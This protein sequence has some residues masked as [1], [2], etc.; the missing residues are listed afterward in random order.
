MLEWLDD[1]GEGEGSRLSPPS[2][3]EVVLRA[4][5]LIAISMR[6]SFENLER[7]S[8]SL[9]NWTPEQLEEL[10][11]CP[12]A[13]AAWMAKEGLAPSLSSSERRLMEAPLGE[14]TDQELLDADWRQESLGVLLWALSIIPALPPYDSQFDLSQ[15][16]LIRG[17]SRDELAESA[18]KRD[19]EEISRARGVAEL[20]HWRSRTTRLQRDGHAPPPGFPRQLDTFGKIIRVTADH[21]FANS[22]IPRPVRHDFPAFGKPYARLT[23]EEYSICTSIVIERHCALNWLCGYTEDWNEVPTDT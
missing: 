22:D 6:A 4:L 20:W 5:C 8:R 10:R 14:W 15:G 16:K 9:A 17:W 13:V 3:D 1:E 2:K 11:G 7:V 19:R 12:Q 21:A 18:Q 23:E